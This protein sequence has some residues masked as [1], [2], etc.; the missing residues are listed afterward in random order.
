[1]RYFNITITDANNKILYVKHTIDL[2][3]EVLEK[4][5]DEELTDKEV[6]QHAIDHA[7]DQT[8]NAIKRTQ[9]EA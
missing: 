2:Q 9:T 5:E 6:Y 7:I 4:M 8:T 1:M 3:E